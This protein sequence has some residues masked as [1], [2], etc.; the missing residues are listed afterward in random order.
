M[1]DDDVNGNGIEKKYWFITFKSLFLIFFFFW[2]FKFTFHLIW[3][4]DENYVHVCVISPQIHWNNF[5][6]FF[7]LFLIHL[8]SVYFIFI[9]FFSFRKI[10]PFSLDIIVRY[11]C[12]A[13][14]LLPPPL[15]GSFFLLLMLDV[16]KKKAHTIYGGTVTCHC[17]YDLRVER[18]F[19]R[20][21]AKK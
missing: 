18:T 1:N 5:L 6:L 16:E 13:V 14:V 10:R 17:D 3:K 4:K 9:V 21:K 8:F 15:A 11:F 19:P 7:C 12:A 2:F 20:S